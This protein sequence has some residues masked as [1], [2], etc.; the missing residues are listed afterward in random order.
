MGEPD[1]AALRTEIG[2]VH[3]RVDDLGRQMNANAIASS[4]QHRELAVGLAELKL[5][6]A[7]SG[8]TSVENKTS[9]AQLS[10]DVKALQLGA[11]RSDGEK[12]V[13]TALSRHPAV[14]W[15]LGVLAGAGVLLGLTDK[16]G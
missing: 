11:A 1:I 12:G 4:E 10:A 8:T 6:T 9:I 15:L 14:I 13:W 3:S 5:L 2:K 16:G 7:Q